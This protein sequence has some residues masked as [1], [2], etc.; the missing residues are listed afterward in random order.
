M[1]WRVR[2]GAF[3]SCAGFNEQ[4]FKRQ[5][6]AGAGVYMEKQRQVLGQPAST[7]PSVTSFFQII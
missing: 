7:R 6:T 4:P 5:G 3:A 1:V 2:F